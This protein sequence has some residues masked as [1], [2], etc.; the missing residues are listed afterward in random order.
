MIFENCINE[1]HAARLY[2][3]RIQKEMKISLDWEAWLTLIYMPRFCQSPTLA[4]GMQRWHNT[5]KYVHVQ[6]IKSFLGYQYTAIVV[7][8]NDISGSQALT[9]NKIASNF[10]PPP[11]LLS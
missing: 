4:I 9:S 3:L 2:K 7:N 8:R 6:S 1:Q 10:D 11:T 5:R